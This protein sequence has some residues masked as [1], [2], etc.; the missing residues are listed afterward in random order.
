MS[1]C[2]ELRV[3]K[4]LLRIVSEWATAGLHSNADPS[5]EENKVGPCVAER[6]FWTFVM[7]MDSFMFL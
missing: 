2:G 7:F 3:A 4:L 6:F 1:H 5:R